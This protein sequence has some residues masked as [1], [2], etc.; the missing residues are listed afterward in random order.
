MKTDER[1]FNDSDRKPKAAEFRR[2]DPEGEVRVYHGNLPHWRQPG[3]TYFVTFRQGD[4]IP[5]SVLAEWQGI[6]DRWFNAHGIKLEWKQKAPDRFSE[7]YRDVPD[8]QRHQ[9]ERQQARMLHDE[10]DRCHGSCVLRQ[11][12]PRKIL[13]DSLFHFHGSRMWLGDFVIMPNH[14]HLLVQPFDQWELEDLLGS[15]K[16]WTS[17]NIRKFLEATAC[18]DVKKEK[19]HSFWQPGSYDRIV[20]DRQELLAFRQYTASNPKRSHLPPGEFTYH[21]ASWLGN[22]GDE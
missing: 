22:L 2:F 17:R 11:A 19:S 13:A 10:L 5:K 14:V 15:I 21:S 9:F 6:R 3:A 18:E 8:K 16:R 1:T 7:A 20:R 4:S 12:E